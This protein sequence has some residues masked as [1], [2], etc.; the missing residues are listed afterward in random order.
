MVSEVEG[1]LR[2]RD[3]QQI[4]WLGDQLEEIKHLLQAE[5]PQ[6][7]PPHPSGSST[8]TMREPQS[9]SESGLNPWAIPTPPSTATEDHAALTAP[10]GPV[11]SGLSLSREASAS[12]HNDGVTRD[13]Y[14]SGAAGALLGAAVVTCWKALFR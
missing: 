8:E 6:I 3:E 11:F 9:Q 12:Q 14:Y 5:I 4:A 7:A 1:R 2:D 10:T 13:V